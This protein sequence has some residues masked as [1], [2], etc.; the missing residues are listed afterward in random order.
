[1][2]ASAPRIAVV[3][4][5]YKVTAAIEAVLAG[6]GPWAWAIYCVDDACPE[7]SAAVIERVAASDPRIRLIRR[8][9]NGGVGAATMTGY[10]AAIDEGADILVKLD[11]DGQMDPRLVPGLVQPIANGSADYV[12]GNRFFSAKTVARMPFVRLVGNVG[13]SFLTKLS[14]GYWDLFDPTNGFTALEA[15][16]ARELPFDRVHPRFFFETDLLFRL[17][18]LRARVVE[19]PAMAVYADEKSNLS[20][21]HTLL[22]FPG[23]HLRNLAK[24]LAYN[25]VLRNF[26]IASVN[27]ALGV[28]LLLFGVAFGSVHWWQ[29]IETGVPATAGTV[30][31]AGLPVLTGLQLLLSWLS[32]D[33]ASTPREPLHPR[34]SLVQVLRADD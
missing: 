8:P 5:C 15:R 3:I 4:P 7:G 26:S 21:S 28:P 16:V 34:L 10:R 11:G 24:R 12:K 22:T 17:G 2:P 18:L 25:Y 6:I 14:T 33:M 32:H 1:M 27:L 30:M 29:S 13:L 20:V 19:V 9:T 23:L 31:L